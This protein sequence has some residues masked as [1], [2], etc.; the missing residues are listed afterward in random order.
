MQ[1]A[2]RPPTPHST[3][4]DR[5]LHYLKDPKVWELRY[6]FFIMGNAGFIPSTVGFRVWSN[7]FAA[8]SAPLAASS[9]NHP[10]MPGNG[11]DLDVSGALISSL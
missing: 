2:W 3:V 4:D 1:S 9:W 10:S 11:W 5:Y 7:P 6:I 8:C